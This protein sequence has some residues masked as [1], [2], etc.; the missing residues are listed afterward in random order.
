VAYFT[1]KLWLLFLV[2]IT[3]VTVGATAG[4]TRYSQTSNKELRQNALQLVKKIRDLVYSYDRKDRELLAEYDRKQQPDLTSGA[5]KA[6]RQQWLKDTDALHDSTMRKYKELYWSDAILLADEILRRLPKQ[7]QQAN[8]LGIY[9]HPT[10]V[11]GV[12]TVA[13]HLELIA[14]LLPD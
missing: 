9:Q 1:R 8:I 4:K 14:K 11:L 13:D 3:A 2:V 6:V 12:Q 7:K 5:A 10:N